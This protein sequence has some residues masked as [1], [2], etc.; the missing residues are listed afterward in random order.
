MQDPWRRF[1]RVGVIQTMMFPDSPGNEARAVDTARQ[2]FLD[3]FFG[4]LTIGRNSDDAMKAMKAMAADA[5][6]SLAVNAAPVL[7]G[8]KLN[9]ASLDESA[10]RTAVDLVK[11]SIED[12]YAVGSPT[13]E[14]LDGASSYP[15]PEKEPQAVD[16]LV[17]SLKELCTYSREEA[18]GREPVW[19]LLETFDR[20]I[21]KKSLV[22]PSDLAA[23]VAERVRAECPNFGL[24]IDMGHLPLIGERF[25]ASLKTVSNYLIHVHIGSCILHDTT[26][27]FYGDSHPAFGVRG[28][29]ADVAELTEFFAALREIGYFDKLLPTGRPWVTF[30]V[31]PQPG[32]SPELVIASCKRVLKEAWARL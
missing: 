1:F 25:A 23:R 18:A 4:C 8:N 10:R 22:G 11:P 9:L 6:A 21:D 20:S 28:G 30:E 24:T 19:V 15:G 12:A 32:Q 27:P 5:H 13:M 14:V 7:L 31:K 17:K 16:Q 26:H 3:D 29:T 2:I